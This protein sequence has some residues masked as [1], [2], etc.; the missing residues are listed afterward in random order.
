MPLLV[1]SKAWIYL[2][3]LIAVWTRVSPSS[4]LAQE[5]NTSS[6]FRFLFFREIS[7]VLTLPNSVVNVWLAHYDVHNL[8]LAQ[9]HTSQVHSRS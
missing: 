2:P 7:G 9:P 6:F 4:V 1:E 5:F 8:G 3:L